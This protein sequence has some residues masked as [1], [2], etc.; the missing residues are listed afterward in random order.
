MNSQTKIRKKLGN[1]KNKGA[2]VIPMPF[3]VQRV[4]KQKNTPTTFQ[5]V[6]GI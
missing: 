6:K 2:G 1:I 5:K 3:L 4:I